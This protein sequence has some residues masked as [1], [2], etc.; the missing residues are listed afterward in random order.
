MVIVIVTV[1][2]S[3]STLQQIP[4]DRDHDRVM[5]ASIPCA[6]R[7]AALGLLCQWTSPLVKKYLQ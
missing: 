3:S 2:L 4:R 5:A 6:S 7:S 1:S